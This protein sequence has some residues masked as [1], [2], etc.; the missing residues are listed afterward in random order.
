MARNFFH[1]LHVVTLN[2]VD[3]GI[4]SHVLAWDRD[5]IILSDLCQTSIA[6]IDKWLVVV[7]RFQI[8]DEDPSSSVIV[9]H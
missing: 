9:D 1:H 5:R 7:C 3:C 6:V 8:D 2:K 4:Q